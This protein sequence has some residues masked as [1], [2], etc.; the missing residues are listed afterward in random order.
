MIETILIVIKKEKELYYLK[1]FIE[2]TR[3]EFN[4]L[5]DDGKPLGGQWNY[6]ELNRKK[7]PK[8]LEIPAIKTYSSEHLLN[9]NAFYRKKVC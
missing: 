7:I 1:T 5:M 6:D 3:K 2:K 9:V 8:G 4:I